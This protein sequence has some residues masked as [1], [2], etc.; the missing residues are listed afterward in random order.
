VSRRLDDNAA[1][2]QSRRKRAEP[3]AQIVELSSERIHSPIVGSVASY[4]R[5]ELRVDFPGNT[6]GPLLARVS[7]ALDGLALQEAAATHQDALL[8]FE[9][10]DPGRPVLLSLLRSTT[11]MVDLL[12]Q[13]GEQLRPALLEHVRVDGQRITIEGKEEVVLRC[14]KASLT[15]RRDGKVLLRGVNVVSQADQVHKVRGGKV[16]IN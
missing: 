4:Q 11:P 8:V 6:R 10:G 7:A 9:G 2:M 16:Q 3:Q 14:G 1:R 5:D 15:L 12:L 13:S